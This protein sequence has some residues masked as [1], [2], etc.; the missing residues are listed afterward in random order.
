MKSAI[1]KFQW[2][3]RISRLIRRWYYA[4][5]NAYPDWTGLLSANRGL[6]KEALN[7]AHGGPRILMATS[8][9][10]YAH[11]VSLESAIAAALTFRGAEVHVLLCDGALPACAECDASLYSNLKNFAVHGPSRDLC[12]DCS[13]PA[14]RVFNKLGL[15]IHRY[16]EWLSA[17]ER[18]EAAQLAQKLPYEELRDFRLDKLSI[19]EHAYAG[20]LRFFA[21]GSL[22]DEPLGEAVFRRYLEAALLTAYATRRLLRSVNFSSTVFTHGIY[23]P[24]GIISEVASHEHVPISTWNVAYRKR[25]FIFSHNDTYHHTLMTEPHEHWESLELTQT[26]EQE[27]MQY[28]A[29]RREG[30]FDW[31][32][33]HRPKENDSQ[34]ISRNFGID[35]SKPV[36]GLLT[37]VS[38]DAQLH[39]PANAFPNMLDWLVTTCKY[40]ETRQDLQLL[41]RVHPG[42][43]SGF[44]KSRQP[45]I[46][47]LKKHIQTIPKN[48]IIVPPESEASTYSLMSV[49]D[50]AIIYGTKMG[51]ELTSVGLPVIVA[52][53][54]WIRNKG[55]T[56][57][58]STPDEYLK[59]LDKLPFRTQLD[60]TVLA[61]ARRYAYHFFFN[62]MIPLPFI[63]PKTNY[64]IYRLKL[65]KLDHLFPGQSKGLDTICNGIL[66]GKPFVFNNDSI[67]AGEEAR[68][69]GNEQSAVRAL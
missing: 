48:I 7:T 35:S 18:H 6:W 29:S 8:I 61:R 53:E 34:N 24:W 69:P 27:L 37:N 40:F 39:Y 41:I 52:G 10:S 46:K 36:I 38:W 63:E 3:W 23:V 31:I 21:S 2:L 57:D 1:R 55:L 68:D 60:S 64:P 43:V 28:L 9:G 50:S 58:A 22:E 17:E 47:E 19:G 62:R 15:K 25:R 20:A 59:L 42:E 44:P 33:F 11:A 67:T 56:Y 30:L 49:C 16:S 4:R 51:V 32:V 66:Q 14:E 45:I 54:A 5:W 12:R 26:K 13:W 65:T